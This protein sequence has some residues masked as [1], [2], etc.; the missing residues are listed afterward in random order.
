VRAR[1]VPTVGLV[2]L[3]LIAFA[4]STGHVLRLARTNGQDGWLAWTVAGAVELLAVLAGWEV[5]QRA[6]DGIRALFPKAVVAGAVIFVMSANLAVANP[7]TWGYVLAVVPPACFFASVGVIET[8]PGHGRR[9]P[10]TVT[11]R[12]QAPRQAT[13]TATPATQAAPTGVKPAQRRTAPADATAPAR[14]AKAAIIAAL[15]DAA[16]AAGDAWEPDPRALA[17]E[18]GKS[19]RSIQMY[20]AEVRDQLGQPNYMESLGEPA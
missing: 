19:L 12:A 1:Q 5:R 15:L 8:R 18:H 20:L 4:G 6:R 2:V 17:A 16:H 7:T 10:A 13:N 9:K 14:T 3:A 11:T